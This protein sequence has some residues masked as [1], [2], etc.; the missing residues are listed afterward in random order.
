MN[1]IDLE[2]I[3]SRTRDFSANDNTMWGI[4]LELFRDEYKKNNVKINTNFGMKTL[5]E[6]WPMFSMAYVGKTSMTYDQITHQGIGLA[7]L[8]AD[9]LPLATEIITRY[10]DYCLFTNNCQNFVKYLLEALCPDATIP[11]TIET[12]LFRLQE[13]SI[14]LKGTCGILPGTYPQSRILSGNCDSFVTA[15]STSWWTAT[16]TSWLTAANY[17]LITMEK[18]SQHGEDTITAEFLGDGQN[19]PRMQ[20]IAGRG[21]AAFQ[22]RL[23]GKKALFNA[24]QVGDVRRMRMLLGIN[25]NTEIKHKIWTDGLELG[26]REWLCGRGAMAAASRCRRQVEGFNLGTDAAEPG[27]RD[28]PSGSRQVFGGGGRRRRR[29]EE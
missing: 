24:S 20:R 7:T 15:S 1:L 21:F 10:P 11:D 18:I 16:E 6:E 29:V 23:I 8:I 27:G 9:L 5:R 3:L 22:R 14:N 4:M 25:V 28:G 17:S 12:V 2:V 19:I 26:G 13:I